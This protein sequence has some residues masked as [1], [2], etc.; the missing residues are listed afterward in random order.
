MPKKKT[1]AK[2]P[3]PAPAEIE[4]VERWPLSKLKPHAKNSRTHSD[5]QIAQLVA[6]IEEFGFTVPVLVDDAGTILAGHGRVLAAEKRGMDRVPV[7]VA[8]GWSTERKRAYIIADHRIA[9]NGGWDKK[10]LGAELSSLQLSGID[11]TL[12][13]FA[14]GEIRALVAN[15]AAALSDP[16]DAPPAPAKPVSQLGDLWRCGDHRI[17]CGDATSRAAVDRLLAGAKPHL[18][19]TDPPYGVNYDPSWRD[20]RAS[21]AKASRAEK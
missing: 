7:L 1:A 16:D 13:G 17:L 20:K 15:A 8:R 18:M 9:E 5:E 10:A 6:S 12:L 21:A 19:V 2:N 11:M 14:P 4:A 3:A